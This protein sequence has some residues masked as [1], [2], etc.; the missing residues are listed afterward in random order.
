MQVAVTVK[1]RVTRKSGM[2]TKRSAKSLVEAS[3]R[4]VWTNKRPVPKEQD[5]P[6][7]TQGGREG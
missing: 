3:K 5:Q 7:S 6:D 2:A 1:S 4:L